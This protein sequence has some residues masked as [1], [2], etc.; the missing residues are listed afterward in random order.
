MRMY[1][2]FDKCAFIC[3][4]IFIDPLIPLAVKV[5]LGLASNL[6]RRRRRRGRN[7]EDP[8]RGGRTLRMLKTY[9]G[10]RRMKK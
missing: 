2:Q 9:K 8:K 6:I 10:L 3:N 4:M 1:I 5:G 7:D